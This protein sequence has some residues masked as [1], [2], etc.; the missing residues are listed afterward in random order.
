MYVL[1][2]LT[3]FASKGK[4]CPFRL[5]GVPQTPQHKNNQLPARPA[6]RATFKDIAK[7]GSGIMSKINTRRAFF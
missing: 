5:L 1:N 7:A 6:A 2:C 4:E 3:Y